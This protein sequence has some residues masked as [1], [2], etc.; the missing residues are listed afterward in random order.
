MQNI[1]ELEMLAEDVTNITKFTLFLERMSQR[2][3]ERL[4]NVEITLL[5]NYYIIYTVNSKGNKSVDPKYG[6]VAAHFPNAMDKALEIAKKY[7]GQGKTAE[8]SFKGKILKTL[9]GKPKEKK[10]EASTTP[11]GAQQTFS[12]VQPVPEPAT[13]PVVPSIKPAM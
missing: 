12:S 10:E 6:L 11:E 5:P 8:I 2:D 3:L 9:K 4:P 1:K 7:Q 13:N